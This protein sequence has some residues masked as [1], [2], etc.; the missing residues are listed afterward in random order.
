MIVLCYGM[1]KS[2]S[3]LAFELCKAILA[4]N[5]YDQR[6]LPQESVKGGRRIN[7]IGSAS[8]KTLRRLVNEVSEAERIA[9]K[10]H[11]S[12]E[13]NEALFLEKCISQ[14]SAKVHVNHRDPREVCL[15]LVDAGVK[16]RERDRQAFSEVHSLTDA[17]KI[18]NRRLAACR[19]WGAIRGA[20]H[21]HYN[22]VAFNTRNAVDQIAGD[23]GFDLPN[24]DQ[25]NEIIDH[26]FNKAF[27][28]RNKAVIDR[29]KEL[30]PDQSEFLQKEIPDLEAFIT[31]V[32][33]KRDNSWFQEAPGEE[34]AIPF[35]QRREPRNSPR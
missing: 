2:G 23:F 33:I 8:I 24:A 35:H 3:T 13:T 29:H 21:L 32:C 34:R 11:A 7:F 10:I 5:G 30:S 25:Y 1:P 4:Q 27:T 26:V 31:R 20:L 16:A 28:Q 17:A 14:G 6:P 15:S 22:D 9:V 12:I 19:R 18:V